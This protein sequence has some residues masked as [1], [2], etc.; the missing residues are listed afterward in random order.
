MFKHLREVL[1]KVE[2]DLVA[3]KVDLAA[4]KADL[5]E[6]KADLALEKRGR[7]A[8]AVKAKELAEA[9]REVEA[10][11]KKYKAFSNFMAEKACAVAVFWVSKEFSD[12]RIA[13]S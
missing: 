1:A 7:E 13:F 5:G 6:A 3:T 12:D 9:K 8:E 10:A 11:V 2:D 4:V